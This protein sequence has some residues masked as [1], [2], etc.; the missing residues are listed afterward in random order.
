MK[1]LALFAAALAALTVISCSKHDDPDDRIEPWPP[2]SF[3]EFQI[4]CFVPTVL[5]NTVVADSMLVNDVLYASSKLSGLFKSYS[6]LPNHAMGSDGALWPRA[7]VGGKDMVIK[8]FKDKNLIY[9]QK[10]SNIENSGSYHLVVYDLAKAPAVF[11]RIY[12]QDYGQPVFIVKFANFLFQNPAT[13]YPGTLRLQYAYQD[14]DEWNTIDKAIK[15]GEATDN[16]SIPITD[17]YQDIRLR[18][19]DKDGCVIT[20]GED[21]T[22]VALTL[23]PDLGFKYSVFFVGGNLEDGKPAELFRWK[24]M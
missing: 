16:F 20:A 5:N 14:D 13:Q 15:F 23:R 10:I 18:V 1:K 24:S 19:I 22:D 21:G 2:V 7:F 11:P 6:G 9:E 12:K 8:L 4:H 17:Q 3:S